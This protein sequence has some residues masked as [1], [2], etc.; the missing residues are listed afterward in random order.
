MD[1]TDIAAY[2][3]KHFPK[4]IRRITNNP[5]FKKFIA[6][7]PSLPKLFD[8]K[9]F[10]DMFKHFKGI[11]SAKDFQ[12]IM[13]YLLE[14]NLKF[15]SSG[16]SYDGLQNIPKDKSVVFLSNHRA[17]FLDA[18][19]TNY[20]LHKENYSTV[21]NGCG[22]NLLKTSWLRDFVRIN[23]GFVVKRNVEDI[24]D[25]I[26]E[27][28]RLSGY[29]NSLLQN[30]KSVWIAHR[31]GRAK[32][33][34]D[35][36]DSVVIAMLYKASGYDSWKEWSDNTVLIPLSISWEISPCDLVVADDLTNPNHKKPIHRDFADIMLELGS[37]KGH[38]HLSFGERI[39]GE[40]R[41]SIVKDLDREI[42]S[43]FRLWDTNWLA[44]TMSDEVSV[45]DKNY[46]L[47]NIDV[48]KAEAILSRS[49]DLNLAAREKFYSIYSNPVKS[50]L[51]YKTVQE[52]MK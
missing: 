24:D 25:K 18:A 41:G 46:V 38:I 48:K 21:Y 20:V 13:V 17:I 28:S 4:F 43:N 16:I 19:Y 5:Q 51:K 30:K 44:Y 42:Q 29:I 50:A 15:T 7:I 36:S 35:N 26:K 12:S 22:D 45:D 1:Y 14:K 27:I 23:K 32:N 2:K 10:R 33:G 39:H 37:P 11:A 31:G 40:K 9:N 3:E 47:D 49:L 8:K 34:I 52:L 6:S